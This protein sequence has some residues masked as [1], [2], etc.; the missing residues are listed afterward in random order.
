MLATILHALDRTIN[1][2]GDNQPVF[3]YIKITQFLSR[4]LVRYFELDGGHFENVDCIMKTPC[5]FICATR[6]RVGRVNYDEF[7]VSKP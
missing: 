3:L 6:F 2:V 4:L 7:F 1:A 5:L